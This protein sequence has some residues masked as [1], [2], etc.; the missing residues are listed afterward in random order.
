MASREGPRSRFSSVENPDIIQDL[1]GM[2]LP[3]PAQTGAVERLAPQFMVS[4]AQFINSSPSRS[5]Y[6]ILG[7][8]TLQQGP[9]ERCHG[10][11]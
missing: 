2:L 11:G 6:L 5:S 7:G 9:G 10:T 1:E 4:A 8:A 3:I